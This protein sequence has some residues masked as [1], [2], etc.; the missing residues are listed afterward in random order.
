VEEPERDHGLD[1]D[2]LAR[3]AANLDR[4]ELIT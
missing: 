1:P 3:I 4:L 2:S